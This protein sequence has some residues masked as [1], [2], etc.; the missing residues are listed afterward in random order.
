MSLNKFLKSLTIIL[1]KQW[2]DFSAKTIE[3]T[4]WI[5]LDTTVAAWDGMNSIEIVNYLNNAGSKEKSECYSIPIIGTDRYTSPSDSLL[6]HGASI[7][8]NEIDEGNQF[9]KGHPAAHIFAPAYLA[10]IEENATGKELIRAF[11]LGYEVATRFAYACNMN[12]DMHPHGTWGTIGGT[13]ATGLL[14]KKSKEDLIESILLAAALPLAT[15]WEAAATGKTVRNL[16]TGISSQIAYQ[17]SALQSSGFESSPHVVEHL[18]GSLI[19]NKVDPSL[20]EKDLWN[21]PLID[22][23]FFKYYP[24]CRFTHSTIDALYGLLR[25]AKV[26]ADKIDK[27]TVETYQLAARLTDPKPK[28]KLAAKFSI[29]YLTA[30]ILLDKDLFDSFS[31]DALTNE[32]VLA[33]AERVSLVES[34]EMTQA[35]PE[36]RAAKVTI[37]LRD[38]SVYAEEVRDASGSFKEPLSIRDLTKKYTMILQNKEL[39]KGLIKST[40]LIDEQNDVTVWA[41]QF[42]TE[43]RS[44][45]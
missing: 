17:V 13:V 36:E 27:V 26:D 41:E 1:D 9:A 11:I 4:K 24:S 25:K 45:A 7:V 37:Q 16:Y 18:W 28:N 29:P 8:S 21:P 2:E 34:K 39:V 6:I 10:A 43:E 12:D 32:E 14:Q 35:L 15:S 33:L 19:S 23:S 40:L 44:F 38:G 31:I 20:F 42:R 5:L 30:C 22:K 3:R